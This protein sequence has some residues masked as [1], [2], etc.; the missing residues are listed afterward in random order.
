MGGP[1]GARSEGGVAVTDFIVVPGEATHWYR[2]QNVQCQRWWNIYLCQGEPGTPDALHLQMSLHAMH[3]P[4][5]GHKQLPSTPKPLT[6]PPGTTKTIDLIKELDAALAEIG[7]LDAA[8][9]AR[10]QRQAAWGGCW[11]A[12]RAFAGW[13]D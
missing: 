3:C 4:M 2:C 7:T 10:V 9:K 11:H 8:E 6:F 5:C 13:E 12:Q 1:E